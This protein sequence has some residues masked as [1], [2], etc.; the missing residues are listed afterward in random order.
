PGRAAHRA[1]RSGMRLDQE[2]GADFPILERIVNGYPL[3]YLDS[4][5]SSQRPRSVIEAMARYYEYSH[6]NV[7]RSIHTLG[8]E[9]T[10]LYEAARDRV[11]RF[12]NSAA[13]EEIVF[14]RNTTDSISLVAEAL[15]RRLQPGDEILVT[16]MEH[17]SNII[18]WQMAA[19]DH[20]ASVKAVPV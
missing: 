10:E 3:V 17:H 6:A 11:Q 16:E 14:T 4:A 15:A 5:A 18:P 8:E 13:R 1:Q 19:R 2:T 20:G 12:V 9:A 7:H